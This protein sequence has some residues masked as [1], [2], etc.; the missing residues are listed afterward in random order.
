MEIWYFYSPG[1]WEGYQGA[2][3]PMLPCVS[4]FLSITL[5]K[6]KTSHYPTFRGL[7]VAHIIKSVFY[8]KKVYANVL[9]AKLNQKNKLKNILKHSQR[10]YKILTFFL[11]ESTEQNQFFHLQYVIV[12]VWVR[13]PYKIYF[14]SSAIFL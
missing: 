7:C 13:V 4:L 11:M 2:W 10:N 14:S 6:S 3:R 1:P 12:I 8:T 5:Y 9:W